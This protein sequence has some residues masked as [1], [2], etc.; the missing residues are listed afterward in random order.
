MLAFI[1]NLSFGEIVAILVVAVLI[2][3]RRLPEVAA[4][5]AV[6]MQ[7]L[8]RGMQDFR[9]ESGFDEEIRKARRLIENPIK[10]AVHEVTKEP[11]T[12]RAPAPRVEPHP[13]ALAEKLEG[14][15]VEDLGSE[16]A[17]PGASAEQ[18]PAAEGDRASDLP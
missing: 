14:D 2:F 12:W 16:P 5:G 9:R 3:G 1:T 11:E 15:S 18:G 13:Q 17:A 8:R 4:K 10:T 7:R 6:H